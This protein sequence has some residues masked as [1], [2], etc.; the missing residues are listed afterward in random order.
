MMT[1]AKTEVNNEP[2][3]SVSNNTGLRIFR[4]VAETIVTRCLHPISTC[5]ADVFPK[6]Q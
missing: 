2:V 3:I 5:L 4:E 1:V 6:R